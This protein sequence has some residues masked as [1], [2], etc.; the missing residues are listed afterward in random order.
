MYLCSNTKYCLL[1]Q[2]TL[3]L[4]LLHNCRFNPKLSAHADLH[5]TFDDNK[6]PIDPLGTRVL[7]REK[8]TKHFT[9]TPRGTNGWY[10]RPYLENYWCV[11]FYI[12]STHSTG[13]VDTVEFICTFIPIPNT[14][15]E[16]YVCQ[17]ITYIISFLKDVNTTFPS[18][19]FGDDTQNSVKQIATLH[20]RAIPAPKPIN[21]TI[22][23]ISPH[24]ISQSEL[25]PPSTAIETHPVPSPR[26]VLDTASFNKV[27]VPA[28][29]SPL[30]SSH[31]QAS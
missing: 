22:I 9:W 7:V 10:I 4:N 20:N 26:V 19:S 5:C 24:T 21:T 13:I 23:P 3:T 31:N 1:P 2:A 27:A 16:D 17:S 14:S 6:I 18:L 25:T 8:T 29:P 11:E 15:S 12:P 30:K 28:Q